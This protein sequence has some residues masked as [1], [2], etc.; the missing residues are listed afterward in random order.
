MKSNFMNKRDRFTLIELLVVIAIIGILASM[1]LPALQQARATAKDVIC[2]S[3]IKQTALI[4]INYTVDNESYYPPPWR[5]NSGNYYNWNNRFV[6]LNYASEKGLQ[7]LL[8]CPEV[9]R[10]YKSNDTYHYRAYSMNG[11]TNLDDSD[12]VVSY[13]WGI[14]EWT[15]VDPEMESVPYQ[16]L[17]IPDPSGTFMLIE[18]MRYASWSGKMQVNNL[19][20]GGAATYVTREWVRTVLQ[21]ENVAPH[22]RKRSYAYADGHVKMISNNQDSYSEWTSAKD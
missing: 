16:T 15:G 20:E 3:N 14:C 22:N 5:K 21:P 1:L 13:E 8:A 18:N 11:G 4:F 9:V 2:L 17:Q 7:D 6:A 12:N 10:Y 19:W